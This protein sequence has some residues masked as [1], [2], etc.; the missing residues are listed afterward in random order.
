MTCDEVRDALDGYAAG[1]V[2]AAVRQSLSAHLDGCAECRTDLAA[3]RRVALLVAQLAGEVAPAEDLWPAI[4]RRLTPRGAGV[5]LSLRRYAWPLAAAATVLMVLSASLTAWVLHLSLPAPAGALA[6]GLLAM[7]ASYRSATV[8]LLR[9]L[10][11]RRVELAPETV[12]TLARN[13]AVIDS[14][15][16]EARAA[17][18]Q[19]PANR[20]LEA[21]LLAAWRQKIS[22]LRQGAALAPEA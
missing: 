19:D 5:R 3:R 11:A 8:E 12:A 18:Q 14:A 9:A 7:E 16:A 2:D 22:L 21:L 20:V 4:S 13:L 1:T 15:L 10:D 17:L 6:P